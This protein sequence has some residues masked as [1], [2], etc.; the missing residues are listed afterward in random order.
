ME[1][2]GEGLPSSARKIKRRFPKENHILRR[3]FCFSREKQEREKR[4]DGIHRMD[5]DAG[6]IPTH[7]VIMVSGVMGRYYT[8]TIIRF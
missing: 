7:L 8:L 6:R 3:L 4:E 1:E 5:G 2:S